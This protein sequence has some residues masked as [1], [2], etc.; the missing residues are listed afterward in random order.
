MISGLVGNLYD[1]IRLFDFGV[2]EI[3]DLIAARRRG[4]IGRILGV[5]REAGVVK[6]GALPSLE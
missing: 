6:V 3:E 4:G 1:D 2:G 5:T